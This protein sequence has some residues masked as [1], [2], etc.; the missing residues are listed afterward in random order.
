MK[1]IKKDG[2]IQEF[3]K[4]K[5]YISIYNASRNSSSGIL[6][7]SDAKI[8]IEDI[9]KKLKSIRK[10]DELTSIYEI[11]GVIV[12]V[13]KKDGFTELLKTYLSYW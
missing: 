7:E 4:D 1:V 3:N 2:R 13:L 12:S 5:I 11:I 10:D 9:D 8:I 6:N